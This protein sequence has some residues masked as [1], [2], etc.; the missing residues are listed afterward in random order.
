MAQFNQEIATAVVEACRQNAGEIGQALSRALDQPIDVS[1]GE[2][3]AWDAAQAKVAGLAVVLEVSGEAAVL[4]LPAGAGLLPAWYRDP[5]PTGKSKLATLAQELSMLLLPDSMMASESSA[6][7][8]ADLAGAIELGELPGESSCVPILLTAGEKT[9]QAQL[10]WPVHSPKKIREPEPEQPTAPPAPAK[11]SVEQ[12]LSANRRSSEPEED[13]FE[14]LPPYSRSLL[15]I[16]VPVMVTLASKKQPVNKI[17][18]LVPG[19]ILQFNKSCDELLDLE[20]SGLP[21]AKGECVKVGDKFGLRVSSLVL[22]AERFK[23]VQ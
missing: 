20:V 12:M 2:P 14:A 18:E 6:V 16:R 21:V 19:S 22:P 11:V 1:I 17:V 4:V 23:P 13:Q 7:A 8:V 3:V 15:H 5:D 9:Q 10:V